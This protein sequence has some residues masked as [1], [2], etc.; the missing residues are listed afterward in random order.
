[1][2]DVQAVLRKKYT[3]RFKKYIYI[4]YKK[5][6]NRAKF[7]QRFRMCPWNVAAATAAVREQNVLLEKSARGHGYNHETMT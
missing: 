4:Y 1:M 6:K 5:N 7:F 3:Q 2:Y